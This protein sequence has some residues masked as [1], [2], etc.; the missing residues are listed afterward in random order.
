[1]P[2]DET[3]VAVFED[4][5]TFYRRTLR[6]DAIASHAGSSRGERVQGVRKSQREGERSPV[7]LSPRMGR[8]APSDEDAGALADLMG[9]LAKPQ[10]APD[11]LRKSPAQKARGLLGG[12]A[13]G[14]NQTQT[15]TMPTAAARHASV[16][17]SAARSATEVRR[18]LPL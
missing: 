2:A 6:G 4:K 12:R 14:P 17:A 18:L 5:F 15:P 3:A 11:L 13:G 10:P 7:S 9:A 8:G 1:V 16:N